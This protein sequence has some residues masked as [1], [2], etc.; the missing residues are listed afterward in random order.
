[1]DPKEEILSIM[2]R[3][4]RTSG[5]EGKYRVLELVNHLGSEDLA[6]GLAQKGRTLFY[7]NQTS[8]AL[9]SIDEAI[10]ISQEK[11]D[12]VSLLGAYVYKMII[13]NRTDLQKAWEISQVCED[14]LNLMSPN[15]RE[16]S[17][18][19][20]TYYWFT[21]GNY[22]SFNGEIREAISAFEHGSN[23]GKTIRPENNYGVRWFWSHLVLAEIYL[24]M[25][26][27]DTAE[28]HLDIYFKNMDDEDL[29]YP[30]ANRGLIQV[31]KGNYDEAKQYLLKALNVAL[32]S[33]E[34]T[35]I[36]DHYFWLFELSMFQDANADAQNYLRKLNDLSD[37][38]IEDVRLKNT[39]ELANAIFLKASTDVRDR[40]NAQD[41]LV[42]LIDKLDFY[43]SEKLIAMKHLCETY[44]DEIKLFGHEP[45]FH[46]AQNLIEQ[47][48]MIASNRNSMRLLVENYLLRAR[49][50]LI[51][52]DFD[53]AE[54]L[55]HQA[56]K[57]CKEKHLTQ[58]GLF[59]EKSKGEFDADLRIMRQ[60]LETNAT[61]QERLKQAKIDD[62]LK[63]ALHISRG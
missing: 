36:R 16:K 21:K 17:A 56:A 4:G 22:H 11:D 14:L 50:K 41:I 30:F 19:H 35:A 31:E 60:L 10:K 15:I 8:E 51:Q 52:G 9:K 44:I 63:E 12:F 43:R 40:I 24:D 61:L 39:T 7:L 59:V 38:N 6:F 53:P 47:I 1:M 58:L 55:F 54:S 32:Q 28:D 5:S 46:K 18:A 23:L 49:M 42:E 34:E 25:G 2:A 27:I 26:E 48:G 33:G 62:Y 29:A 20:E 3:M 45:A 37:I 57:I 13:F